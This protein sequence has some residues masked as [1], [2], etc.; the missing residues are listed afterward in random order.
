MAKNIE[1]ILE[2]LFDFQHIAQNDSLAQVVQDAE[3]PLRVHMLDMDDL[4]R[5]AGGSGADQQMIEQM[6]MEQLQEK[7][8]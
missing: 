1:Q 3:S 7:W 2:T 6:L 4:A 8:K 5:V